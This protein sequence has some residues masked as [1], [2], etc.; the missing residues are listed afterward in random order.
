MTRKGGYP[1]RRIKYSVTDIMDALKKYKGNI[2]WAARALGC[3][4]STIYRRIEKSP[5]LQKAVEDERESMIDLAESSLLRAVNDGEAW[6]VS[7]TLKTIGKNRGY[8][9]RTETSVSGGIGVTIVD[10]VG[11]DD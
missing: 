6:A 3:D 10:D 5:T 11:T 7:L 8:V 2:S 1:G 9:E 4:R